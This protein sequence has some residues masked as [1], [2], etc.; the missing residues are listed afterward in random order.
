MTAE[1][2]LAI[3]D[4]LPFVQLVDGELVVPVNP[5]RSRHQR[6]VARIQESF[7]A[8][9][10]EGDGA[11]ELWLPQNVV[12]DERNV[13]EPDLF[14]VPEGWEL[15]PDSAR[16]AAAPPLVIEV[17]SPS[18]RR[19]DEGP[20]L[21]GYLRAGVQEVWLVDADAPSVA[22]HRRDAAPTLL[23]PGEVLATPLVPGW[24]VD[25]S[26]LRSGR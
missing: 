21:A 5:P 8:H 23:G 26:A 7:F 10:R 2:Y 4:E 11:G 1:E 22:V 17:L 13:Y 15:A 9:R 14:W 12:V 3:P 18:T 24:E 25:L 6:V 19:I 16:L 20:K